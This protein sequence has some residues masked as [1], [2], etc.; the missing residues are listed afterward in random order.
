M[1]GRLGTPAYMSPEQAAGELDRLGPASDIYSLGA[2]LYFV[3]TGK[4]PFQQDGDLPALLRKVERG[5]FPPPSQLNPRVDRAL[6]AVCKKAMALDPKTATRPRG[7]S[8]WRSST[9]WPTSQSRHGVSPGESASS[10]GFAA[11]SLWW[12]A[13]L[14]W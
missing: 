13:W 8:P 1:G 11:T 7:I 10:A 12:P 9:G 2:T 5:E 3:L 4:P 14:H 6:D